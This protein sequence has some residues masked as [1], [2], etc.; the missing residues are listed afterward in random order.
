MHP[1]DYKET[2]WQK[3]KKAVLPENRNAVWHVSPIDT[4]LYIAEVII[5]FHATFQ[6][7]DN[8]YTMMRLEKISSGNNLL[9]D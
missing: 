6:L 4:A 5:V 3:G 2:L 8:N 1:S 7:S 9:A